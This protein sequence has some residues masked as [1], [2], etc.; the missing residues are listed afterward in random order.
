LAKLRNRQK[1]VFIRQQYEFGDR[2]EY[3]FGEVRL[4]IGGQLGTYHMAVIASAAGKFRWCKLY[5][6]EKK[7]VFMDSHVKFFEYV[8]GIYREVVYDNMKNVV[9]KFIGKNE[10]ELNEDL[11]RMSVY[12]GF[13]INVTNCFSGNESRLTSCWRK[14][15]REVC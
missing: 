5:T 9:T 7:A 11:I 2:I 10:K 4:I 6:N 12:Y 14:P 1:Q 13:K 15:R 8:G 3:D